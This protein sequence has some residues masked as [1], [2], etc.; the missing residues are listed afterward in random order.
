VS[1]AKDR[2]ARIGSLSNNRQPPPKVERQGSA[3]VN[4]FGQPKVSFLTEAAALA[5]ARRMPTK[6]GSQA[7]VYRC[8]SCHCFHVGKHTPKPTTAD[9]GHLVDGRPRMAYATAGE[10]R[11]IIAKSPGR[12]EVFQC[13]ECGQWHLRRPAARAG[14]RP[15]GAASATE[16]Q[17]CS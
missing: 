4:Q 3:H 9:T 6:D 14:R 16:S 8:A 12:V 11:G 17:G 5:S 7:G 10:A 15:R 2:R 13:E 1:K